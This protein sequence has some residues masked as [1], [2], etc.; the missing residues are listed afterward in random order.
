MRSAP[1][2][3]NVKQAWTGNSVLQGSGLPEK[4]PGVGLQNQALGSSLFSNKIENHEQQ[5][6]KSNRKEETH[7]LETLP[8]AKSE[9]ESLEQ[10]EKV[11]DLETSL[12]RDM[13]NDMDSGPMFVQETA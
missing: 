12:K 2:Q 10:T 3:S 6:G 9:N 13:I 5:N 1:L 8:N 7:L 4:F 11:V